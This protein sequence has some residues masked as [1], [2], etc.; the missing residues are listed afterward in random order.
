MTT[1]SE[2]IVEDFKDELQQMILHKSKKGGF[3]LKKPL[4]ILLIISEIEKGNIR[5]NKILFAQ[6]ESKLSQLIDFFGGRESLSPKPEQPFYHLNTSDFWELKLPPGIKFDSS[7]TASS[8]LLRS[9]FVYGTINQRYYE[10]L[11][12]SSYNRALIAEEVLNRFWYDRNKKKIQEFLGLPQTNENEF[13]ELI[14]IAIS[15]TQKDKFKV[16]AHNKSRNN[17]KKPFC[18]IA[19]D[20]SEFFDSSGAPIWDL[21]AKTRAP[22]KKKNGN[23]YSPE[24]EGSLVSYIP[25]G[26]MASFFNSWTI[27]LGKF[28]REKYPYSIIKIDKIEKINFDKNKIRMDIVSR[29]YNRSNLLVKDFRWVQYWEQISEKEKTEKASFWEGFLNNPQKEIFA[30]MYWHTFKS[31]KKFFWIAGLHCL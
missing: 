10:F 8:K 4:L 19:L 6:I 23:F 12:S 2:E 7:R 9:G 25:K 16:I 30:M 5:E 3:A 29:G 26:E 11:V 13:E 21:F 17:I 1:F 14:T 31:G 18:D 15:E 28:F 22:I 24:K 27:S 20:K